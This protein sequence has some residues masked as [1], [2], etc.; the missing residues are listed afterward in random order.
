MF[1]ISE[2]RPKLFHDQTHKNKCL[3]N[4]FVVH[5]GYP[6]LKQESQVMSPSR[7]ILLIS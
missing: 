4:L 5:K 6:G 1:L 7:T 2:P 3:D